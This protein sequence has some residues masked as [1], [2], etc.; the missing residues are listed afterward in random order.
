MGIIM[1]ALGKWI[2]K[3]STTDG[4]NRQCRSLCVQV[5]SHDFWFLCDAVQALR[6]RLRVNEKIFFCSCCV[7]ICYES[8]ILDLVRVRLNQEH[9]LHNVDTVVSQ[10]LKNKVYV[11][12]VTM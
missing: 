8:Y 9:P 2:S 6:L 4:N 3:Y 7:K 10:I 11:E 1:D 5:S 12:A